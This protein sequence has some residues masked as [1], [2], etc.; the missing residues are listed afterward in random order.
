[1]GRDEVAALWAKV[2][3]AYEGIPTG[4]ALTAKVAEFGARRDE[5]SKERCD[6][7]QKG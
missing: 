3:C 2:L 1:M 4:R 7:R 5:H 6:Q